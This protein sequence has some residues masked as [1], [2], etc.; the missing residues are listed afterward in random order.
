MFL[1]RF[2]ELIVFYVGIFSASEF[3][4]SR[5][6]CFSVVF[7]VHREEEAI[8]R[9][10]NWVKNDFC[11]FCILGNWLVTHEHGV[12]SWA[13]G[14]NYSFR[15]RLK[16]WMCCWCNSSCLM[17]LAPSLPVV[18]P[19]KDLILGKGCFIINGT[20]PLGLHMLLVLSKGALTGIKM[21]LL[22]PFYFPLIVG[23]FWSSWTWV[24][25]W[26]GPESLGYNSINVW[27]T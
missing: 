3:P 8:G 15:D 4:A 18:S 24:F 16:V 2:C 21:L 7:L 17:W 12:K 10:K 23:S 20:N 25:I 19:G 1:T 26:F 6:F 22:W 27:W 9:L 13:G 14:E 11:Q 5:D